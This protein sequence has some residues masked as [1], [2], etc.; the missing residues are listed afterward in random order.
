MRAVYIHIPFCKNICSYCDFCKFLYNEKWADLYL[1]A[2]NQEIVEYYENDKVKTIYVG[3][4]TPSSL[5]IPQINKL[6]NIIKKMN[7]SEVTEFTF[8]CNIDD[9]NDELLKTLHMNGVNRLSIGIESFDKKNLDFMN[10]KYNKK[11]I[12]EKIKLCRAYEFNNI[13]VDLIYALPVED[14]NEIL[15]VN[16]LEQLAEAEEI[17]KARLAD[18]ENFDF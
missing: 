11:E 8:E 2:L 1:D 14:I 7:I 18:Q 5:N 17:M 15:G 3:G 16:T 10:R 9:I 13:N 4:G 6:F 12:F